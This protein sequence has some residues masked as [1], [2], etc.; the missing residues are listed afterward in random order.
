M[1]KLPPGSLY[2]LQTLAQT[3]VRFYKVN[4]SDC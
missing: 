1:H 2:R 3:G 4:A